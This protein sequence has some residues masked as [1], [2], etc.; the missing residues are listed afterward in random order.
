M[1]NKEKLIA[2]LNKIYRNDKYIDNIMGAAGIDLKEVEEDIKTVGTEF[3][4]DTMDKAGIDIYSRQLDIT[5]TGELEDKRNQIEAKWKTTGKCDLELLQ[6]IA[7]SW[8]NGQVE[9]KFL[10]GII[11]VTFNSLVGVPEDLEGLK[12]AIKEAK[13]AHLGINYS[14]KYRTFGMVK[15]LGQTTQYWK[16]KGYTYTQLRE[17][18]EL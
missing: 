7:N 15:A 8:R 10:N 11:Q 17:Q 9:I 18:E 14:F 12:A 5:T 6:D 13:P 4:F 3:F 16:D 2:N 1:S